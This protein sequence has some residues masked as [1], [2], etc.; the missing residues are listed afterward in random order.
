MG[1]RQRCTS[2]GIISKNIQVNHYKV[3]TA[4]TAPNIGTSATNIDDIKQ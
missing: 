3:I 2:L 4:S 1:Q